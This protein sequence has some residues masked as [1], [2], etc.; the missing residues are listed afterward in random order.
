MSKV[1][2]HRV[3]LK[4]F[5]RA[6]GPG[7]R[8]TTVGRPACLLVGL[9][10]LLGVNRGRTVSRTEMVDWIYGEEEDGGPLWADKSLDIG[11]MHLRRRGVPIENV[12]GRG[13]I[14]R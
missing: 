14:I 12:H 8:A 5:L 11:I 6:L 7:G 13:F 4:S 2:I 9:E 1:V 3:G 10:T